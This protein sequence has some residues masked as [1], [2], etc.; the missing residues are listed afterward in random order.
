MVQTM[1][2]GVQ[3]IKILQTSFELCLKDGGRMEGNQA[4]K[5]GGR[6]EEQMSREKRT[7]SH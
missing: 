2:E 3:N 7:H 6:G 4:E 5:E 1:E